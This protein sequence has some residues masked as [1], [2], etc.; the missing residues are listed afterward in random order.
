MNYRKSMKRREFKHL[1][2]L[3]VPKYRWKLEAINVRQMVS[4]LKLL[5]WELTAT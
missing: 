2:Q 3:Q 1:K 4:N 5:E